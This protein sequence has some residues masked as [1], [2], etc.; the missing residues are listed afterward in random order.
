MI[1]KYLDIVLINKD[2]PTRL[3]EEVNFLN[4]Y[5][6]EQIRLVNGLL[7]VVDYYGKITVFNRQETQH[8]LQESSEL[9]QSMLGY[10]LDNLTD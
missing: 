2:M 9:I 7:E 3:K 6:V 4:I 8:I 10:N 5:S 1:K